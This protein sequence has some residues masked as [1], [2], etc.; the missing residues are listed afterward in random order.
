MD[1][2]ILQPDDRELISAMHIAGAD[3][4]MPFERDIFLQ[5]V[6]VAGTTHI[7]NIKELYATLE[8]GDTVKLVREPDNPY[9]EYAVRIDTE[10]DETIGYILSD[11][12]DPEKGVKLGYIP[13]D[14]N[15]VFARLM[16]AGKLLYG[17]VRAK[18][19][20]GEWHRI[21]IK[22]YMKD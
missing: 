17:V 2:L 18:E 8:E 12:R 13:R 21:V 1:E 6:E 15:R 5:G 19:M 4:P 3:L 22:I 11:P 20:I 9:D 10:N 16:D 7:K 14:K